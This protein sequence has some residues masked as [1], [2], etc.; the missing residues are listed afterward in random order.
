MRK[1]KATLICLSVLAAMLSF[2]CSD[3]DSSHRNIGARC[4]PASFRS[5]ATDCQDGNVIACENNRVV[6]LQVCNNGCEIVNNRAVCVGS[7][8]SVSDC[9]NVTVDGMCSGKTL[10]YCS[11]KTNKLE[12]KICP[13]ACGLVTDNEGSYYDCTDGPVEECGDVTENGI[14]DD[15]VAKRCV[16]GRLYTQDCVDLQLACVQKD[17]GV[18]DCLSASEESCGSIDAKGTC[19]GKTLKFCDNGK[20]ETR[21]CP[22]ACGEVEDSEGRAYFD[23]TDA[24]NPSDE[25]CGEIDAHGICDGKDVK[26]CDNQKLATKKCVIACGDKT[27]G[28]GNVFKDCLTCN[29][30]GESGVCT[31]DGNLVYC[32]GTTDVG[33]TCSDGCK[34]ASN[35]N[36]YCYEPCGSVDNRGVCS[37]DSRSVSYCDSTDMLV[38]MYCSSETA[39]GQTSNDQGQTYYDCVSGGSAPDACGEITDKGI[40]EGGKVRKYCEGGALKSEDCAGKCEMDEDVA[41][42][43]SEAPAD[44]LSFQVSGVF[45]SD[46][47]DNVRSVALYYSDK[48]C[49]AYSD[50]EMLG[51]AAGDGNKVADAGGTAPVLASFDIRDFPVEDKAVVAIAKSSDANV[52]AVGCQGISAENANQ[53]VTVS[54][55]GVSAD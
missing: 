6:E 49:N 7:S 44:L 34:V 18:V 42:C 12:S 20:L 36:A 14:C 54:V 23:C 1:T 25:P 39:C 53:T 10:K 32:N 28:S 43:V 52:I 51:L 11:S 50:G 45:N 41:K 26:F 31:A 8:I 16:G 19:F 15:G 27:D 35:N 17:D 22:N 9:G 21:E 37:S 48:A 55:L 13:F 3:D 30:I 33:Q 46:S 4:T 2:G 40:C 29:D 38:T 5:D 47:F 24:V